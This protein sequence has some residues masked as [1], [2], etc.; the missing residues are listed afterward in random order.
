MFH[1]WNLW[2]NLCHDK[3]VFKFEL[4]FVLNIIPLAIMI[5]AI[6]FLNLLCVIEREFFSFDLNRANITSGYADDQTNL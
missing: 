5:A 1:E 4:I 3:L 6:L 2:R